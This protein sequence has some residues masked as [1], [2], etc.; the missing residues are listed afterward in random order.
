M[1]EELQ[2]FIMPSFDSTRESLGYEEYDDYNVDS[3]LFKQG[4]DGVL[5]NIEDEEIFEIPEGYIGRINSEENY[6]LI[7]SEEDL[8]EKEFYLIE[9]DLPEGRYKL[10]LKENVI[11]TMDDTEEEYMN[12]DLD[13]ENETSNPQVERIFNLI[14]DSAKKRFDYNSLSEQIGDEAADNL[15]FQIMV[16]I[17]IRE[18]KEIA[19]A[20]IFNQILLTGFIID[21]DFLVRFIEQREKDL[22]MEILALQIAKTNLDNNANPLAVYLQTE[23]FLSKMNN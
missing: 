13:Y 6:Y 3:V 16:S 12:G 14:A 18:S 8:N 15:L 22:A 23:D 4:F 19:A 7:S 21:K 5:Q 20:K 9:D 10:S 17:A 2:V 1:E 11:Y